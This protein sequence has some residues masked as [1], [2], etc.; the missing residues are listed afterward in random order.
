MGNNAGKLPT[1]NNSSK[2][3]TEMEILTETFNEHANITENEKSCIDSNGFTESLF[4]KVPSFG[5]RLFQEASKG[6]Q[7]LDLY[8]FIKMSNQFSDPFLVNSSESQIKLYLDIFSLTDECIT[9]MD[10]K[11][12]M[13]AAMDGSR[14]IAKM[15][16]SEMSF[17]KSLNSFIN[18][19]FS[20]CAMTNHN[21]IEP[22]HNIEDEDSKESLNQTTTN[23]SPTISIQLEHLKSYLNTNLPNLFKDL[24][25]HVVYRLYKRS[26]LKKHTTNTL[27]TTNTFH[28]TNTANSALVET[29]NKG[30]S[31]MGFPGLWL[32]SSYCPLSFVPPTDEGNT[33]ILS[34]ITE[35]NAWHVLYNSNSQGLSA[36]GFLSKIRSYPGSS[37]LFLRFGEYLLVMGSDVEWKETASKRGGYDC[38]LLQL[39]PSFKLLQENKNDCI[40][41]NI[42]NRTIKKALQF[43]GDRGVVFVEVDEGM[44]SVMY[45][46]EKIYLD[47]IEV[48][49][50][51]GSAQYDKYIG[52]KMWEK[53]DTQKNLN[54]KLKQEEWSDSPDK[55]LLGY[56]GIETDHARKGDV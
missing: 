51:G 5:K 27:H 18:T 23:S 28:T 9:L 41:F 55:V 24:H 33:S 16:A 17:D 15:A 26:H 2:E 13:K 3:K 8:S 53:K 43:C 21:N 44:S 45:Q 30:H 52:Q 37:I 11:E 22:N 35:N 56:G 6:S 32:I 38:F 42:T 20:E 14:A 25:D 48:W 19:P 46:G 50:C 31:L 4:S 49:G 39:L 47:V 1:N 34:R 36:N 29:C 7:S 40:F 10:Y 54:R 12:L